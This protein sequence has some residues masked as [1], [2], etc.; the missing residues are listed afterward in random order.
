MKNPKVIEQQVALQ[1]KLQNL[2]FNIVTCGNC[3]C[4]LIHKTGETTIDC[5]CGEEM[6]ICDCPDLWTN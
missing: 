2:G 6:E 5:I 3:G 4:V 1:N